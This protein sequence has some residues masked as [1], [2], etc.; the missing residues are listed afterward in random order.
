LRQLGREFRR[1]RYEREAGDLIRALYPQNEPFAIDQWWFGDEVADQMPAADIVHLHWVAEFIDY[2]AFFD[3]RPGPV[4]W[5][6]HDMNAFTGGCHFDHACGKYQS[7]C[8]A[9]P[10][11]AKHESP[12]EDLVSAVWHRKKALFDARSSR[13]LTFVA[14]SKWLAEEAKASTLLNKFPVIHAPNGIDV[15]TFRPLDQATVRPLLGLPAETPLV[16][17]VAQDVSDPRKGFNFLRSVLPKL[18]ESGLKVELV[19]VGRGKPDI[20][21]I[22]PAHHFEWT[23]DES[24][25]CRLYSAADVVAFPSMQDN[26]P[27]VLLESMACGTPAVALDVGGVKELV[28]SGETGL[29]VQKDDVSGMANALENIL[30]NPA[31]SRAMGARAR[32]VT[33]EQY[34]LAIQAA[35]YAEIYSSALSRDG[36]A[37]R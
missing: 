15:E 2:Q 18:L 35:R 25:V 11:L 21:D 10:L 16:L 31:V 28:I 8:E 30:R 24:F 12:G 13:S 26:F 20:S 33:V 29:L 4:V 7:E 34:T 37:V 9:C 19:I 5:T 17:F 22:L 14:P 23:A 3:A 6:L 27:N 36:C 1:R 32:R